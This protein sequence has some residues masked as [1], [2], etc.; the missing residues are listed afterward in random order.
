MPVRVANSV[1]L[2]WNSSVARGL[3]Y[4]HELCQNAATRVNVVTMSMGGWPGQAWADAI[5]ALYEAGVVVVTA[6]GNNYANAPTRFIVYP[7]RFG[8]VIAACGVM[9]DDN[10]Y[11]NLP[12][13]RI[14]PTTNTSIS[15]PMRQRKA[16]SGV[17]AIGS[18]RTLKLV[19]TS[20]GQPVLALK[21]EISA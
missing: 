5:N 6:A 18:P 8:R 16:S 4:V 9:A 12:P 7:A 14:S 10:P 15:V 17:Q 13:Q 1:V 21:A 2:F 19:L 3:D 11:A 20:T